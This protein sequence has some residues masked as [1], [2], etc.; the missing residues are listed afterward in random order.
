MRVPFLPEKKGEG[1]KR[2][3]EKKKLVSEGGWGVGWGGGG[4]DQKTAGFTIDDARGQQGQ[5]VGGAVQEML[6]TGYEHE[7]I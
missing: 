1:K 7:S 3:D 4:H 6:W 5:L 2:E